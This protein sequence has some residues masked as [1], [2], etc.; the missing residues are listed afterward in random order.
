[1]K[2]KRIPPNSPEI[3]LS[4][5]DVTL[6]GFP[7][8]EKTKIS[9]KVEVADL[10]EALL[11]CCADE[12]G[13]RFR[14]E[15]EFSDETVTNVVRECRTFLENS[16]TSDDVWKAMGEYLEKDLWEFSR[17]KEDLVFAERK[18][19]MV[20][21]KASE[22]S[23]PGNGEVSRNRLMACAMLLAETEMRRDH[24]QERVSKVIDEFVARILEEKE[25]GPGRDAL[26][27][28]L[29]GVFGSL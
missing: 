13:G 5:S 16:T 20:Q 18:C 17:L 4:G 23:Q 9:K 15:D 26:E 10:S 12:K 28:R 24:L 21:Q 19:G 6:R 3:Q 7:P 25:A 1:M 11:G 2:S 8:I 22:A 14:L 27:L 29:R